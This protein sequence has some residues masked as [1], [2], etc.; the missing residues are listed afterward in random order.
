MFCSLAKNRAAVL[1][2]TNTDEDD[3]DKGFLTITA[4]NAK[5]TN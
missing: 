1:S 3:S 2:V 5:N 4:K